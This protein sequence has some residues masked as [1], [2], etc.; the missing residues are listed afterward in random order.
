MRNAQAVRNRFKIV[1]QEILRCLASLHREG[2]PLR[3]LSLASGSAQGVME[4]VAEF[5]RAYQVDVSLLLMDIDEEAR[6]Y[7]QF[8]AKEN[9]LHDLQYRCGN[10]LRFRG[11][12]GEFRPTII[13]MLGFLDYLEDPTAIFLIK[14]INRSLVDG[15]YF[16]TCHIHD[17]AERSFLETVISWGKKPRMLYRTCDQL[18]GLVW[19]GGFMVTKLITEPHRIHT[20]LVAQKL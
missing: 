5:Q 15:G 6:E 13:E 2:K 9:G 3:L 1:K 18:K 8:Y 19:S 20:V 16:L 7:V 11:L 10:V 4:A 12:I 17:N 14:E